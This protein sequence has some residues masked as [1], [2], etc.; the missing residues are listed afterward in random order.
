MFTIDASVWV[1]AATADEPT[2]HASRRFIDAVFSR[3][4][5]IILPTLLAVEIAATVARRKTLAAA[6]TALN[7]TLQASDAIRWFALD[8]GSSERFAI[9]ASK[10]RLRAGDAVYAGV[11]IESGSN[12]V[13][14]DNEHHKYLSGMVTVMLPEQALGSLQLLMP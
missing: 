11:A 6:L 3:D 9:V 2:H 4:V 8:E 12:L 7:N 5:R 14:L 10:S 13:S 1:S